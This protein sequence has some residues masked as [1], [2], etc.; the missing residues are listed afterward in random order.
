[1][2][3]SKNE[4][5]QGRFS[6]CLGNAVFL[7]TA[8][9]LCINLYDAFG[10]FGWQAVDL[11]PVQ[12]FFFSLWVAV[13]NVVGHT[14]LAVAPLFLFGRLARWIVIPA[15]CYVVGINVILKYTDRVYHAALSEIWPMLVLNTSFEEMKNFLKFTLTPTTILCT[16][17]VCLVLFFCSRLLARAHYPR[18]SRRSFFYGCALIVPFVVLNMLTMNWHFGLGQTYYTDFIFS[19]YATWQKMKGIDSACSRQELPVK[20][21]LDTDLAQAPNVIIILGESET[22]NNW[23]L[24]GYPRQTTPHM[25]ALCSGGGGML[26]QCRGDAA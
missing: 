12:F 17:A 16:F 13:R 14:L 9:F 4:K 24:Y 20:L 10:R 1:M 23:H 8:F 6:K 7:V 19:S 25:D 5:Q 26:P 21:A 2:N 11:P 3:N 22:R 18:F 15:L